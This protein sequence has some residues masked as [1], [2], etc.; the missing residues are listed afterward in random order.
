MIEILAAA[1]RLA[2]FASAAWII[3]ATVFH[4]WCVPRGFRKPAV[5]GSWTLL[6]GVSVLAVGHAG[7]MWAQ[8]LTL[9]PL[10][11]TAADWRNLVMGT[12][13]GQIWLIRAGA[14][15]LLLLCVL[16][17]VIR[18]VQR[19]RWACA[20]AAALYLGLAPWGG[21]GAGAEAPWQVLPPNIA[22]MLEIGRASCRE[23]V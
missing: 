19:A 7:L 20:I 6:I 11:G 9:V 17:G 10:G 8:M 2:A 21:H 3:G 16:V 1:S 5:P 12:H 4:A 22:H 23:R 13:F 18:P 14:A 15:A